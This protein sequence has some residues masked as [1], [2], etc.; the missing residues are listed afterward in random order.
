MFAEYDYSQFPVVKVN[1]NNVEND[2]DFDKF[3]EEWLK[4]YIQKKDF[5]FVFD[6]RNITSV[7]IKYSFRMAEFIKEIKKEEYHY[8]QKSIILINNTFVKQ[9]LNL[10]LNLQ[11]P[12]APVYLV[13]NEEEI[14]IVLTNGDI[15]NIICIMPE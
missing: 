13:N 15:S 11:S 2:D 14:D 10:I 6:T 4:L 1:F 7:P 8:L 9:M 5:T 3:L 12:V